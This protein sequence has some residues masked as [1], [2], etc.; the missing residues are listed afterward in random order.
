MAVN[1]LRTQSEVSDSSLRREAPR[2]DHYEEFDEEDDD[3]YEDDDDQDDVGDEQYPP[4][5]YPQAR[6]RALPPR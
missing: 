2:S 1:D 6:P 5:R 4:T 3:Q